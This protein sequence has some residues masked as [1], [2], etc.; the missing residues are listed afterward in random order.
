MARSE[1]STTGSDTNAGKAVLARVREKGS[2]HGWEWSPFGGFL[3]R[4]FSAGP[5]NDA[6]FPP[7]TDFQ[8]VIDSVASRD[9]EETIE[10]AGP[11]PR[12]I[13]GVTRAMATVLPTHQSSSDDPGLERVNEQHGLEH[14][15]RTFGTTLRGDRAGLKVEPTFCPTDGK[16]PFET[17]E[18]ELRSAAI[19]DENGNVLFE[20]NNCEIPADW[21]QLATNVVVSKYFYGDPKKPAERERSVRQLV[22]RVTRTIADWGL[23][24]GYF[25][26]PED[27][28]NF[29]RDLT[30]LCLHQ[31]GAF[32]SPVW[33]NV[34]L[35]HQYGV[36][37][38]QCNWAWDRTSAETF[39]PKNPYEFPQGS[40]CFIQSVDDN[41]EDIMRLA[42]AEAMLFKFG[43][44]TGTDLS[45]IR[46]S[47][48]RLSGGGTPS[49]P[50]SFMRVYD[51][52]AGVIK[53]GGKT[54]R[55]AKMQSLKVWHPDV[56]EFIECKWSEEK[57]AHALIREGY[58][59]NF[60][61]EAY[62]SVCFQNANLSVRV[63]DDYME[64]VRDGKRWHTRWISDKAGGEAPSYDA[65]ELLNK[66]SECAWHCGDPGVQ[67]DTTIN[68]WHT[69]PNS[70]DINAS[71]PCSEYM[72]L[73]D[74]ACN[75]ASINLMKF[76]RKRRFV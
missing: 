32:N 69:C 67:Y 14:A 34:G 48:E 43:S 42:C 15:T 5:D 72:F 30:W 56:M 39:Q 24:D 68:R 57:K 65:K 16:T 58:D 25:D 52:I 41:M 12:M 64:S 45:T 50:L 31:H 40:A 60:N 44:G 53:S 49:G 1:K 66:M 2:W 8:T 29:Y 9:C 51:S 38:A 19:K 62:S 27:G 70:G 37:G 55:A 71:N 6:L 54:R 59:S 33:F 10:T 74:T 36:T 11:I 17:T 3:P 13:K 47:R 22:H 63:T 46:S 35:H 23:A 18:W 21:S 73:D 20:Q 28:E 26:S 76:A 4:H 7:P 75:L 61:G